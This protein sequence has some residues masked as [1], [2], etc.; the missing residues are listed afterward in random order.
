MKTKNLIQIVALLSIVTLTFSQSNKGSNPFTVQ[1]TLKQ[2]I[3]NPLLVMAI[4]EQLNPGFL[5]GNAD[6]HFCTAIIKF[7]GNR[8]VIVGTY[9]EWKKFFSMDDKILSHKG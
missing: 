3:Q 8:Y 5:T 7:N 4:Y 9:Q 2:A 6:L 1:T